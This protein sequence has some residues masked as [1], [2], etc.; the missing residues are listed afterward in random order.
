[1]VVEFVHTTI[2]LP[3]VLGRVTDIGLTD[4]TVVLVVLAVKSFS[5]CDYDK[6]LTLLI[7]Q[8]VKV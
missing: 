4:F 6:F 2:A 1:V 5:K 3:A 8:C 7:P